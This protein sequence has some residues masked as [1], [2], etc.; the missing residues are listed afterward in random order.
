MKHDVDQLKTKKVF[1]TNPNESEM[2]SP[3]EPHSEIHLNPSGGAIHVSRRRSDDLFKEY[4][5][6]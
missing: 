4:L 5:V 2:K 3:N 1:Q 6:E